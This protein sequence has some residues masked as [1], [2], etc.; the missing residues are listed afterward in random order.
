MAAEHDGVAPRPA[1]QVLLRVP[2][3]GCGH[4]P[5]GIGDCLVNLLPAALGNRAHLFLR[6]EPRLLPQFPEIDIVKSPCSG[7]G[8]FP[9]NLVVEIVVLLRMHQEHGAVHLHRAD[10]AAA[11]L[12]FNPYLIALGKLLPGCIES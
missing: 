8:L 2:P 1:E 9:G 12:Q 10:Q 3:A 4:F 6:M 5:Q 7:H 11:V